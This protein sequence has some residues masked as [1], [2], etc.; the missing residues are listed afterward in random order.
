MSL[1][2]CPSRQKGERERARSG[3]M[4]FLPQLTVPGTGEKGVLIA[5]F[6]IGSSAVKPNLHSTI[7][8]QQFLAQLKADQT[9]WAV[10]G[11]ADCAG[12]AGINEPL[13]AARAHSV[14]A[15]LPPELRRRISSVDGAS[16][17]DCLTG[18]DTAADRTL[19]RSVAL[20]LTESTYDMPENKIEGTITK[21]KAPSYDDC[22]TGDRDLLAKWDVL[23]TMM[24]GKA[25]AGLEQ[26]R[27]DDA[28]NVGDPFVAE[29]LV[30]C[31]G[32]QGGGPHLRA[33]IKGFTDVHNVFSTTTTS[34]SARPI[35]T[36]T[37]PTST[38]CGP[39]FTCAWTSC[40]RRTRCT[41][42]AWPCTRCRTTPRARTMSKAVTS[43]TGAGLRR[44]C[45]RTTRSPT[46][47]VTRPSP[48]ST[49]STDRHPALGAPRNSSPSPHDVT[50]ADSLR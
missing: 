34:T 31:F 28:N 9:T 43:T 33:V 23:A 10:V 6:D 50:N 40:G 20:L 41:A 38:T 36:A 12:K 24:A 16:I 45:T 30:D 29:L 17:G 4:V 3:A 35:A 44:R 27:T 11:F 2:E 42:P 25:L 26:Y 14:A 13:R 18:N 47:T 7:Y 22:E 8:W 19:N 15:V 5:N 32:F 21:P 48:R 49:T 46:Q 1:E 37:T 39:T